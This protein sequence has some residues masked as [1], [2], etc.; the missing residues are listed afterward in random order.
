MKKF[1][2]L[3]DI[4]TIGD[5]AL[6]SLLVKTLDNTNITLLNIQTLQIRSN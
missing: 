2:I 3:I 1:Q 6:T 5:T 4:S